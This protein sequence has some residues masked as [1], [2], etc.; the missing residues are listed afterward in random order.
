[1]EPAAARSSGEIG[2][3]LPLP[4]TADPEAIFSAVAGDEPL[5]MAVRTLLDRIAASRVVVAVAEPLVALVH[6]ELAARGWSA[7]AVVAAPVPG[8]RYRALVSGLQYLVQERRSP[9]PVLVHDY[10]HPL[11]PAEVIDR[12]IAALAAGHP[13][14]VPVVSV[15]DSVKSVDERGTVIATMDRT[16]LHAV[17]Y[18]RGFTTSALAEILAQGPTDDELGTALA[19]G[20]P[21]ATVD[22]HADAVRFTLPAD[23]ELLDAIITS[24]R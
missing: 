1:M 10:R 5:V 4:S 18:P 19:A 9:A 7:V 11:V 12:V 20:R 24:R 22:G 13:I 6:D 23:A 14:V 2:A 16:T 15:T 3:I 21:I 17:Q 8:D